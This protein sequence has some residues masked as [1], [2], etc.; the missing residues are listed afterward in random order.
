M[1]LPP[2]SLVGSRSTARFCC[3]CKRKDE[4]FA[5]GVAS[6]HTAGPSRGGQTMRRGADISTIEASLTRDE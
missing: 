1:Y 6:E 2:A 3:C 4:A 5:F